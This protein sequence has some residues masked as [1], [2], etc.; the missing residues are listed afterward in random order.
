MRA[1]PPARLTMAIA[2][3]G[4]LGTAWL[5]APRAAAAAVGTRPVVDTPRV[6]TSASDSVRIVA[7]RAPAVIAF[8]APPPNDSFLDTDEGLATLYDDYMYYWADSRPRLE[9]MGIAPLD[10]SVDWYDRR[11]RIR[12]GKRVWPVALPDDVPVGY[13]FVA[14]DGPPYLHLGVMVDEDVADSARVLTRRKKP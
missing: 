6:D 4:A 11:L 7:V 10:E 14:A 12:V 3:L 13:L 9:A 5:P 1:T 8:Y 2:L